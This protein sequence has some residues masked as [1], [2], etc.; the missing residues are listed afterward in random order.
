MRI[1]AVSK[2]TSTKISPE[3]INTVIGV[4]RKAADPTTAILNSVSSYFSLKPEQLKTPSRSKQFLLPR[5]ISMY[6]LREST[7]M[8]FSKIADVFPGKDKT[9]VIYSVEK[10]KNLVKND[11]EIN[12]IVEEARLK[13][14]DVDN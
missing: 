6:L 2:L 7:H 4:E 13:T 14:S 11:P 3:L 5:Q 12:R 8:T 10:V 1:A 9:T